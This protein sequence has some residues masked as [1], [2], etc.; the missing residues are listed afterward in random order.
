MLLEL[1]INLIHL[2][3]GPTM[4]F[5]LTAA[6]NYEYK[7]ALDYYFSVFMFLRLYIWV[8][9]YNN[10]VIWT[11]A[12]AERICLLNGFTPDSQFSIKSTLNKSP[13][14]AMA[15]ALFLTIFIFGLMTREFEKT[16]DFSGRTYQFN[17][18]INSF[19]CMVLTLTTVGYGEIFPITLYGRLMIII[20]SIFGVFINSLVI[21]TL[22]SLSELSEDQSSAY[23]EL[24]TGVKTYE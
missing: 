18:L 1:L 7:M 4:V 21:V 9:V 20:V 14:Y 13:V 15:I 22:T 24:A 10:Y 17:F 2:P 12:R 11:N 3:P 6:G 16:I 19:W 23:D 5:S 8:R